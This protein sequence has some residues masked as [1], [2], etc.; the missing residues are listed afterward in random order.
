MYC[1]T[2][3]HSILHTLIDFIIVCT[4][5]PRVCSLSVALPDLVNE[6]VHSIGFAVSLY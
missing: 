5:F 3:L 1:Y 6:D 4:P 2:E